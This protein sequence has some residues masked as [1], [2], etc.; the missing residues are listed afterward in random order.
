MLWNSWLL[1]SPFTIST[2]F[3]CQYLIVN[4]EELGINRVRTKRGKIW[5]CSQCELQ[6]FPEWKTMRCQ[7][8]VAS[9]II[10]QGFTARQKWTIEK[11]N[12]NTRVFIFVLQLGLTDKDAGKLRNHFQICAYCSIFVTF[13]HSGRSPSSAVSPF[14]ILI[15]LC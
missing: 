12:S 8:T 9:I 4:T 1:F 14:V 13:T 11:L 10:H 7:K 5:S 2:A 3:S 6:W 15:H